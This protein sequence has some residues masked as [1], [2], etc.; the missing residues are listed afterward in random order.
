MVAAHKAMEMLP[1]A[2]SESFSTSLPIS[3]EIAPP[4]IDIAE[5][6]GV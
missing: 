2:L 3:E 6:R 5:P 1:K 4:D